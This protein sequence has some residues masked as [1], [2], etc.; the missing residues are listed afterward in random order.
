MAQ[1]GMSLAILARYE[2]IK[3]GAVC[4]KG[5]HCLRGS[6]QVSANICYCE[7]TPFIKLIPV[8]LCISQKLLREGH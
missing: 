5:Y 8:I 1:N 3:F 4:R 7:S 6:T 2:A